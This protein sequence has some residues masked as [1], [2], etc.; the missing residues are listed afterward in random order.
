MTVVRRKINRAFLRAMKSIQ[1]RGYL[2]DI[3]EGFVQERRALAVI[4]SYKRQIS[5][6]VLGSSN[7][8]SVTFIEPG[9]CIPLNHELEMLRDDERKEIRNILRE[10]TRNIRRHLPAIKG[11]QRGLTELD[12]IA[13]RARLAVKLEGSLPQIRKSLGCTSSPPFI[14]C[15]SKRTNSPGKKPSPSMLNCTASNACW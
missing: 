8:G 12:W 13:T 6:A 15:C 2:A 4:S 7:T 9:A 5:G 11:Y 1:E 14:R 3:R 10:L